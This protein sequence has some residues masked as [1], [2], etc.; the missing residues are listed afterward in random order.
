MMFGPVLFTI[1]STLAPVHH[2]NIWWTG[3]F[4]TATFNAEPGDTVNVFLRPDADAGAQCDDY[5]GR[6]VWPLLCLDVDF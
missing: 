5:G 4:S 1:L 2:G 3:E 6:F